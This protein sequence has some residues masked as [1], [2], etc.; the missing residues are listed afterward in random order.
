MPANDPTPAPAQQPSDELPEASLES[1]SGGII[2]D[3]TGGGWPTK[4][5]FKIPDLPT[6]PPIVVTD[7]IA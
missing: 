6:Y 5:P 1:V 2:G 4:P 3:C 7:T